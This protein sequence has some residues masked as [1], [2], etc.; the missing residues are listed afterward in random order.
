[1]GLFQR[2]ETYYQIREMS[3]L[4]RPLGPPPTWL[5]LRHPEVQWQAGRWPI[6]DLA[7]AL[8]PH[9]AP[10]VHTSLFLTEAW[11]DKAQ[12]SP[13]WGAPAPTVAAK[14]RAPTQLPSYQPMQILLE[15]L[16]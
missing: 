12:G 9:C 4:L 5:C 3:V 14:Q 8:P 1:M 16:A 11:N 13:S 15:P 7:S 2:G 10:S 6:R